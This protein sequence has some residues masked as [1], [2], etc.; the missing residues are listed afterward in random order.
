M[1]KDKRVISVLFV[2][3]IVCSI[4]LLAEKKQ[5]LT[6]NEEENIQEDPIIQEND[7]VSEESYAITQENDEMP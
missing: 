5:M 6:V 4:Y 2:G 1:R 7:E 3:I